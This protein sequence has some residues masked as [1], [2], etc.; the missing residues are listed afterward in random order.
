[1]RPGTKLRLCALKKVLVAEIAVNSIILDIGSYDG[2]ISY[3]LSQYIPNLDITI[4]DIDE[5]GLDTARKRGLKTCNAS[6]L[7]LP[8]SDLSIDMVLCLDLLEHLP[9]DD[10]AIQEIARVL[11]NNGKLILTT[12]CQNGVIFP[13]IGKKANAAVNRNWGHVRTGYTKQQLD[14]LL[15]SHKLAIKK[16]GGYF[17]IF[18]R[19]AYWLAFLASPRLPGSN[20][21]YQTVIS[22]EPYIKYRTQEHIIIARKGC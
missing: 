18:T 5:S 14:I 13:F 12:P 2:A 21:L 3:Y 15:R 17:N 19:I 7:E 22:L 8:F 20:L 1:M 16:I 11:K 4:V 9:N 6:A 10:K